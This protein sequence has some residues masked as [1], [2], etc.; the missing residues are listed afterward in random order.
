MA[1]PTVGSLYYGGRLNGMGPV[2]WT[3]PGPGFIVQP[4]P[5]TE[6]PVVP[7]G[8]PQT[9]FS[10]TGLY[11][12]LCNHWTNTVECYEVYD[13]ATKMQAAVLVCPVCQTVQLI[14]EPYSEWEN[15]FFGLYPLSLGGRTY[16]NPAVNP[17]EP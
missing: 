1:F 7:Q 3:Q 12:L 9:P 5:P 10:Y 4:Q 15:N 2:V 17:N 8:Y 14:V 6:Y 13:P 16:T 11:S